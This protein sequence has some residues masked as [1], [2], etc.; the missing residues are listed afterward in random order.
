MG[1][2]ISYN[3]EPIIYYFCGTM[4]SKLLIQ[5]TGL[6]TT[7]DSEKATVKNKQKAEVNQY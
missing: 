3:T 5:D 7:K 2:Y 1:S 4:V 6:G